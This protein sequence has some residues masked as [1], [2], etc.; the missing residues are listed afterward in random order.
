MNY[1]PALPSIFQ[2][3]H[4]TAVGGENLSLNLRNIW[5]TKYP[6]QHLYSLTW[7]QFLL[8]SLNFSGSSLRTRTKNNTVIKFY[9]LLKVRHTRSQ[10]V[11]TARLVSDSLRLK[12]KHRGA[13]KHKG[14]VARLHCSGSMMSRINTYHF[15]WTLRGCVYFYSDR[16]FMKKPSTARVDLEAQPC[17]WIFMSVPADQKGLPLRCWP[18]RPLLYSH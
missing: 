18:S 1:H 4:N 7:I 14:N 13:S 2:T 9:H 11:K 6:I 10:A 15:S 5:M 8:A 17:E 3:S 16:R 12:W